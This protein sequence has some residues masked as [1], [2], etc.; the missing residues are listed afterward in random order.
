MASKKR[1][2]VAILLVSVVAALLLSVLAFPSIIGGTSSK[3]SGTL[4]VLVTDPPS[5]PRGVTALY[6]NYDSVEIHSA[7]GTNNSGWIDLKASGVL[8]LMSLVNETQSIASAS[9]PS[10]TFDS[11][12]FGVVSTAVTF[13]GAN[14]T[15]PFLTGSGTVT[16]SLATELQVNSGKT[17]V[18]LIDLA[19]TVLSSSQSTPQFNVTT[20]ATA[21]SVPTQDLSPTSTQPGNRTNI[22]S[23]NWWTEIQGQYSAKILSVRLSP[24][25]FSAL[26]ENN[27]TSAITIE[28]LEIATF[29]SNTSGAG[30]L[31]SIAFFANF[32]VNSDGSLSL[33]N[34][35]QTSLGTARGYVLQPSASATF[36][37]SGQ[38]VLSRSFS[39][40]TQI[41]V[42]GNSYFITLGGTGIYETVSVTAQ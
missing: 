34:Q 19:P 5:V 15:T 40:S 1:N 38:V 35:N 8:N 37:F 10:G 17:S 16:I 11:V 36:T 9:I 30:S 2:L 4:A 24:S 31:P 3:Q 18:L 22:T 21:Y 41:I 12:R 32:E 14:Y 29:S 28:S 13:Q 33:S 42:S 39:G 25:S 6:M 23:T 27:G 26:V 7:Q 20:S